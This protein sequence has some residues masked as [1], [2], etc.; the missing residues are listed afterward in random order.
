MAMNLNTLTY[1]DN[2]YLFLQYSF[3]TNNIPYTN[4]FTIHGK[5][6]QFEIAIQRCED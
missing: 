5:F 3:T 2:K 4:A 6:Y 1:Y